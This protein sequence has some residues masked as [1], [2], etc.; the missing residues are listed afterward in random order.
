VRMV[1]SRK[2]GRDHRRPSLAIQIP[3]ISSGFLFQNVIILHNQRVWFKLPGQEIPMIL[4]RPV[5]WSLCKVSQ[6]WAELDFGPTRLSI[7]CFILSAL[8]N[9]LFHEM[10]SSLAIV[11]LSFFQSRNR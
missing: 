7:L 1:S 6:R 3:P 9:T 11:F 4:F 2:H 10:S 5:S 8:L